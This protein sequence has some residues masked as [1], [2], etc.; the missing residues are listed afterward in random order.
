MKKTILYLA[1]LL[2]A[3]IAGAQDLLLNDLGYF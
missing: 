2:S 1:L 3:T